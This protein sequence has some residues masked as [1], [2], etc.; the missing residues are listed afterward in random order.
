M[1]AINGEE[2]HLSVIIIVLRLLESR[3]IDG[4]N[5]WR[6]EEKRLFDHQI[7][8]T[9]HFMDRE[10][11]SICF[12][13][14][15]H[16]SAIVI[17]VIFIHR[18]SSYLINNNGEECNIVCR[19]WFN[20]EQQRPPPPQEEEQEEDESCRLDRV[21]GRDHRW[22]LATTDWSHLSIAALESTSDRS[23]F[24]SG[25]EGSVRTA[26][27]SSVVVNILFPRSDISS[28]YRRDLPSLYGRS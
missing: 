4:Q 5:R 18:S 10:R 2:N 6:S 24:I 25:R 1:Q 23:S 14:N 22:T 19:T 20:I 11:V 13:H 21:R 17:Q 7:I 8:E 28:V 15:A 26:R 9:C 12:D 27:M 16:I 3:G